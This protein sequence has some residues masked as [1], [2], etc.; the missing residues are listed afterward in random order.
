M[1]KFLNIKE[2][3]VYFS[4]IIFIIGF[5]LYISSKD[6]D[7]NAGFYNDYDVEVLTSD[8][9]FEDSGKTQYVSLPNEFDIETG[10]TSSI[11]RV[12]PATLKDGTA[13]CFKTKHTRV[14][15]LVDNTIVYSF[16]WDND[17]IIGNTP[18]TLWNV[19][20]LKKEYAGKKLTIYTESDYSLYSGNYSTVV[21]GEKSD[22]MLYVLKDSFWKFF[23]SC[24]PLVLGVILLVIIPFIKNTL[25]SKPF[26]Y[27]GIF[28]IVIGIWEITESDYIQF[29]F[30]KVFTIQ[31]VNFLM[32]GFIPIAIIMA[33]NSMNMIK[34]HYIEMFYINVFVYIVYLML[35]LLEIMD[36]NNSMWL[37]HVVLVFDIVKVFKDSYKYYSDVDMT[38]FIPVA[39]SFVVI[40][41][42][43]VI[44][45][46]RWYVI[47]TAS[48]GAF[49]RWA[50][51]FFI[52]TMSISVVYTTLSVQKSNV[53]KETI[54][55]M[56]YTD[57]LTGLRNRR[58]FEEDTEKLV[59]D[60]I[61]FT[62]V[63]IDMN[64]LKKINDELG[65]KYGDEALIMVAGGLRKFD[66]QGEK[67]YRMGG[68][69]FNVVCTNIS[70]DQIEE[71]C[72]RINFE[73]NRKE[74]FPGEP[75]EIAYGYF[76]FSA[77]TDREL[78]KV[79]AQADKKMYEKKIKMKEERIRLREAKASN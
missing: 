39:I 2:Y 15:V 69:E 32:F 75:L 79:I 67:S 20:E 68:D 13:I 12:L 16:G 11:H 63:A 9:I 78:Y 1:N 74:Y 42:A 5:A 41:V 31:L 36:F 28:L 62:I 35:Q 61:N 57:A 3:L 46:Y 48:E 43:S 64:N 27:T 51:V 66:E 38:S 18:G 53:E 76:R 26:I 65:H 40:L 33:F 7:V 52:V 29:L 19:V 24:I 30:N 10:Y 70:L 54:I 17:E 60:K 6:D 58:C 55:N 71:T 22:I 21:M 50:M 25:N 14:S 49:L 34:K 73:L 56:A 37:I 44:D 59:D 72:Q 4:L 23:L 8:W 47:P 45:I 77:T